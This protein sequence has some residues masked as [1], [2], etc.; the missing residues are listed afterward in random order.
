VLII[1]AL[2]VLKEVIGGDEETK[3]VS[4]SSLGAAM[5]AGL[6]ISIGELAIGFPMG[7]S[8]LPIPA[9]IVSIA[10]QA[11][12]ATLVG[13]SVGKRMGE[14]SGK[15]LRASRWPP[16]PLAFRFPLISAA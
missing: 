12:V 9:T 13:I 1:V 14:A 6:G 16:S 10:A 5:L 7:T 4:F 3:N 11:F 15:P 8:G 2:W